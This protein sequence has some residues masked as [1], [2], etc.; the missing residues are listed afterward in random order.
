M[1]EAV[2][3]WL[4][5]ITCAALIAALAERLTPPG[6][7]RRVGRFTTGLVLLLAM[8]AP[9]PPLRGA[10]LT[11]ALAEYRLE[12][13]QYRL[14]LEGETGEA[15]KTIIEE[16]CAAYIQDKAD[17]LGVSCAAEVETEL[18][19]EGWPMPRRVTVSGPLTQGQ[20]EELAALI[21]AELAVPAEEQTYDRR[22]EP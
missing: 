1:L 15:M 10:D 11:R 6:P 8:L 22:E 5:G 17:G 7:V 19:E 20:L 4:T 9:L 16:Q 2:G 3:Q 21:E 18:T 12:L 13:E 14:E